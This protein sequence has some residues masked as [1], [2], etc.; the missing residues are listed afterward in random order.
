[1]A[2]RVRHPDQPPP[3][4]PGR[5]QR[6]AGARV[7]C[8]RPDDRERRGH[9][10]RGAGRSGGPDRAGSAGS[11]RAGCSDRP[12]GGRSGGS[13]VDEPSRAGLR[14]ER[15]GPAHDGGG[16][17]GGSAPGARAQ[18][19]PRSDVDRAMGARAAC[20][21]RRPA[22]RSPRPRRPVRRGAVRVSAGAT[23]MSFDLDATATAR[24]RSAGQRYTTQRRRLVELLADAG[25]PVSI[26]DILAGGSGL[27]QSSVY[28]NLAAL[29]QAGVVRRL[30]TDE[31]FGR[32]ELAADL[33]GHHHHLVC[34][35][36]GL[37]SLASPTG[38]SCSGSA[39]TAPRR[40]GPIRRG[41]DR[42]SVARWLVVGVLCAGCSSASGGP[43]GPPTARPSSPAKV[44]IVT[45]TNGE[46]IH[47]SVVPVRVRLEN[48][49]IVAATTTNIRPDQGHLHLYL[50]DQ[51]ES[52][53][54]S[55]SATLPAVK[56]GLHVLRVEFV[57]SDHLPFDP[58]VIAQVAFEVKR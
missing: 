9:L 28:R 15:V 7:A 52:M 45:P 53:N 33:I 40:W 58:R 17:R 48:A 3:P 12:P 37:G 18:R 27:K 31:E 19:R 38:W 32:Y 1:M 14:A 13:G 30:V 49:T 54:F 57:A 8:W 21:G 11:G 6:F 36:S 24:L 5:D 50:D 46:V 2:V 20:C 44:Q 23:P 10:P 55:T 47:G 29:E 26:P 39:P 22:A 16:L 56:P 35:R 4:A 34:S 25:S 41:L 51:I 42:R 43:S